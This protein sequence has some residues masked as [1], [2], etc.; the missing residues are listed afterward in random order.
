MFNECWIVR[1]GRGFG[2]KKVQDSHVT[3][4][5]ILLLKERSKVIRLSILEAESLK[6]KPGSL[7][8]PHTSLCISELVESISKLRLE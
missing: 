8:L 2:D 1:T 5:R 6:R 3:D 7:T 4:Y